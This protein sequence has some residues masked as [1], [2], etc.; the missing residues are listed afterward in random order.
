MD[1]LLRKNCKKQ[2]NGYGLN[3]DNFEAYNF[4]VK[5]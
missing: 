4:E 5:N 3:E 2:N 1:I